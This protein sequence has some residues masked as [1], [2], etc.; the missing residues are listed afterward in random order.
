MRRALDRTLIVFLVALLAVPLAPV[1]PL[2]A[3][4]RAP[5]SP[6]N[7]NPE[8]EERESKGV[9]ESASGLAHSAR[10]VL[11]LRMP[12]H[13]LYSAGPA[14]TGIAPGLSARF[15]DP[16]SALLCFALAP[17]LRALLLAPFP[18]PASC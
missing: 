2:A 18:P 13:Q 8:E 9:G 3:V 4:A 6:L 10:R 15:D 16:A 12:R 1:R 5:A 17:R 7:Q 14:K 11:R